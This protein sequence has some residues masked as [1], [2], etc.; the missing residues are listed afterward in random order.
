[1]EW[2]RKVMFGALGGFVGGALI[3]IY[4]AV[5]VSA[6]GGLEEFGVFSFATLS[7]GLLGSLAGAGWGLGTCVIPFFGR[8]AEAVLPVSAA[9]VAALLD[10]VVTRFRVIRD[11][12][13]ESLPLASTSGIAVHVGLVV[14]AAVL[15]F[16]VYRVMSGAVHKRGGMAGV[17]AAGGLLVFGYAANVTLNAV[18]GPSPV[19]VA[20]AT[21]SGSSALLI[22]TDTLRPDYIGP[23]GSEH[24]K[25][26]ALDALA[27]DSVV[28]DNAYAQSSWTRPSVA[29]ILTSLY[30]A[31]HSVM[32][33]TDLLPDDVTTLAEVMQEQGRRTAG[34]VTNINVAPSF[35]FQQG[36][37]EY[38]YLAPD[39]FFGATDSASKLSLY[40]GMRLIRE[41]FLS[42][43]KAV[44]NY[45]QD[46]GTVNASGLPW[47]DGIGD[48]PFFTLVHYMDPHDPYFEIPYNGNAVARV[49][50]PNPD[51]SQAEHLSQ[52]YAAN[53][54]Y[55]D[56]F[57]GEIVEQLKAAG[58]YESTVIALVA[59][60]GEEFYEHQGW[61]HGTT[62]YDEQMHVPM[63]I[64]R[65][66]GASAGSRVEDLVR[67]IDVAP[68]L[69][70]AVGGQAP[71]SFQGRDL[72]G[73]GEAPRAVY[74]EE[75]HEGNVLEAIRT[76]RWKLIVANEDNPRG[77]PT[78]ALFDLR[79][80]PGER[81]NLADGEPE[82]VLTLTADMESLR[83]LASSQAVGGATGELD[84][85]AARATASLGLHGVG[86]LLVV[87]WDGASFDVLGDWI[88]SGELPTL[89]SL[90]EAG[91]ARPLRSTVPAVT[92]PAWTTFMTGARPDYHG[93][94]DFTLPRGDGYGV[95]FANST[96]PS[97]SHHLEPDEFGRIACGRVWFSGHVSRRASE[98]VAGVWLRHAL[99]QQRKPGGG[100]A[101]GSP[102]PAAA[103]LRGP[104]P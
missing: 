8:Q 90:L 33:K 19:V 43:S 46:A 13:G 56:G 1:M 75:D 6:G 10:I 21:G 95:L 55:L 14:A 72:F 74:A 20:P 45:Y 40:G 57:I 98:R 41:R 25:T 102:R 44:Q 34:F 47:L 69:L 53:I 88:D 30:A 12:F 73:G 99:R 42:S 28:F 104:W 2:V 82:R 79:E 65:L 16:V 92:F 23:Y 50:T 3:G 83:A 93:V 68:T 84:D 87:G 62:L 26:P 54:E 86:M 77:L 58:R 37:Q 39:F 94:T 52:L 67:L 31:S 24:T 70:A 103:T 36:F 61:W 27:K 5:I 100:L 71:S 60:H 51:P 80:D 29:S 7:Y 85:A 97:R 22:I 35:Q 64:K 38:S 49:D 4:E 101:G 91:A 15:F 48:Q 89:R 17:I 63:I 9:L 96:F 32:H 78:T 18:G 81:N 11:V 76:D 66:E 59:D